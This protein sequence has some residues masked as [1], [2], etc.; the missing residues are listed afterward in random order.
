MK[1]SDVSLT[2]LDYANTDG[3]DKDTS[4]HKMGASFCFQGQLKVDKVV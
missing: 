2:L 3:Q 1:L 4:H